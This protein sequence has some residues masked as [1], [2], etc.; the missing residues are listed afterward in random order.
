MRP[1]PRDVQVQAW[2]DDIRELREQ[3]EV[4]SEKIENLPPATN[5][6]VNIHI[7]GLGR[8]KAQVLAPEFLTE[9][10][11]RLPNGNQGLLDLVELIHQDTEGNMNVKCV[12]GDEKDIVLSY[13]DG[14]REKWVLDS[15]NK[16][17]DTMIRRPRSMLNDHFRS[18]VDDFEKRLTSALYNF[19]HEWFVSTRNKKHPV[20][21]DSAM[22]LH[23]MVK[24]WGETILNDMI[25]DEHDSPDYDR[26]S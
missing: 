11:K 21:E 9:C 1:M 8:D 20:Y 15:K 12:V 18:N 24:R 5:N 16:V 6:T 4:L 26:A 2:Y 22:R 10:L 19:V 3:I 14:D 17:I 23:K 13:Y 25:E 7:N